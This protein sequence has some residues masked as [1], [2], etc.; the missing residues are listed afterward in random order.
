[1]TKSKKA[2]Q[3]VKKMVHRLKDPTFKLNR[4]I[5]IIKG[6]HEAL[7]SDYLRDEFALMTDFILSRAYES[8][9]DWHDYIKRLYVDMVKEFL[10]Q[11]PNATFKDIRESNV[12]DCEKRVRF[13]LKVLWKMEQQEALVPWSFPVGTTIT[14]LIFDKLPIV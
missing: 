8:L 7:Q 10:G 12:E 9:S 6:L 14:H 13:T 3:R 5:S 2:L 11:L 1:M 4:A